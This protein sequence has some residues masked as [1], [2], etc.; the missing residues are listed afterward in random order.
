MRGIPAEAAC[1]V[2]INICATP[3]LTVWLAAGGA[4]PRVLK[5]DFDRKY[6][7][8]LDEIGCKHILQEGPLE[9][10]MAP[11]VDLRNKKSG[12]FVKSYAS[13]S[14][15]PNLKLEDHLEGI[16]VPHV[17]R[18][19]VL[20]DVDGKPIPP[21]ALMKALK[22][23]FPAKRAVVVTKLGQSRSRRTASMPLSKAAE[24]AIRYALERKKGRKE[25]EIREQARWNEKL[26]PEDLWTT[27]WTSFV[28]VRPMSVPFM[29]GSLLSRHKLREALTCVD[30]GHGWSSRKLAT[31]GEP[32]EPIRN[33]IVLRPAATVLM[34]VLPAND[35]AHRTVVDRRPRD[36]PKLK[37]A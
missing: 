18:I 37:A 23:R 5:A 10:A 30:I 11:K 7:E 1:V 13:S 32:T 25:W 20:L 12:A 4:H 22:K 33:I 9:I 14:W 36:G 16:A 27:G 6:Q 31:A 2:T 19:V 21:T 3:E 24:A 26:R 35:N 28:D 29:R 17:H 15:P 34:A 8:A